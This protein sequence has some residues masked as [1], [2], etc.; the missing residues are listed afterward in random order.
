M[1]SYIY[2]IVDDYIY[3]I[4]RLGCQHSAYNGEGRFS[5]VSTSLVTLKWAGLLR[6]AREA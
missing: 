3:T 6:Q 1:L 2:M 4:C 5:A